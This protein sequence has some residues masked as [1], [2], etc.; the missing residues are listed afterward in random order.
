MAE[1]GEGGPVEP[2]P[3][4][5]GFY[6]Q[7]AQHKP[8]IRGLFND[9]APYYDGINRLFSLGSGAWYRRRCL[10]RAGLRSGHSIIDVAVGT[11]LLA[12]EAVAVT[13]V[14]QA[15]VGIDLSEAMLAVARGKLDIA[16]VQGMAE[17]LPFADGV[18]DFVT[19]GYALRHVADLVVAFRE[20]HR[21]LRPG[22]TVLLLEIGR[23]RTRLGCALASA[24]LGRVVPFLCGLAHGRHRARAL[25]RYYWETIENC[26]PPEVILEAMQAGGFEAPCCDAELDLF[27]SYIGRKA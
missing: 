26:V 24:Y 19:M 2:H 6:A 23:P 7:R 5:A 11:G 12:R 10:M 1:R 17:A 9:T 21:V 8:F 22:G 3:V 4:I 15:V 16:L 14:K 13:G 25:M 20:F 18:A 27:R